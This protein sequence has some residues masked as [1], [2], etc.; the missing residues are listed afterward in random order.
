MLG[1]ALVLLRYCVLRSYRISL[2]LVCFTPVCIFLLH[3]EVFTFI[4]VS[5]FIFVTKFGLLLDKL[6]FVYTWQICSL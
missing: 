2:D 6:F 3:F 5:I 1:R 4:P